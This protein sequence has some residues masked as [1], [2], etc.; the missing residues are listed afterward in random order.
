MQI[1]PRLTD[2]YR[3][4]VAKV[5][6]VCVGGAGATQCFLIAN[7]ANLWYCLQQLGIELIFAGAALPTLMRRFAEFCYVLYYF[8]R[9]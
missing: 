5:E 9:G 3:L 8:V 6:C 7:R 4:G 1:E 2:K